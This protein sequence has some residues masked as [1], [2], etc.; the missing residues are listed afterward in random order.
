MSGA[1]AGD[2]GVEPAIDRT[3]LEEFGRADGKRSRTVFE[4]VTQTTGRVRVVDYRNERRLIVSGDILSVYPLDEDWERL[5]KEY[6][7][8]ALAAVGM[9]PRPRVLLIGLGGGTQVHM[10]QRLAQPREITMIER[11][12]VIVRVACEWFGLRRLGGLEFLCGDALRI[13]PWLTQVGRQFDFVMEDA[14]YAAPSEV[15]LP[16]AQSLVPLVAPAGRLVINRHRRGDGG[17][18][19]AALRPHFRGVRVR[20]VRRDGENVLICCLDPREG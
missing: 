15:G 11:D 4:A 7:W 17:A 13:V 20:R 9:P 5:E 6:W 8:H 14:A 19:A 2:E 10:L 3:A 12:P 1:A 16:L 18:V